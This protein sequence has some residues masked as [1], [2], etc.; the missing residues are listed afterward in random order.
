MQLLYCLAVLVSSS[1]LQLC[2]ADDGTTATDGEV[3]IYNNIVYLNRENILNKFVELLD[4]FGISPS[5]GPMIFAPSQTAWNDFREDDQDR[6]TRWVQQAEWIVHMQHLLLW[7]IS[8]EE[9]VLRT[10]D[11]FNGNRQLIENLHGNI[12]IDQR[13]NTLDGVPESKIILPDVRTSDGMIHVIDETIIPPYLLRDMVFNVQYDRSAKFDLSHMANIALHVGLDEQLNAFYENGITF[14][15]PPNRR[16]NRVEIDV[17]ELLAEENREYARD[18]IL[19]HMID[20]NYPSAHVFALNEENEREQFLINS[21]Y[22]TNMWVTTTESKLRFQS[23][24]VLVADQ[25]TRN[26]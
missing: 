26:G 18:F 12:T 25:P 20:H 14:L 23:A 6:W 8:I 19:S 7:H 13:F 22:G 15:V 11:I 21:W 24:D 9:N 1:V 10:R 16:F 5:T 3:P 4:R 17:A 2:H